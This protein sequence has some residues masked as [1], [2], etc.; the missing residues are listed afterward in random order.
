MRIR[1]NIYIILGI[2][3]IL[4]NLF[5]DFAEYIE[6]RSLKTDAA[7]SIGYFI[8]SHILLI[9][10]MLLL[11]IAYKIHQKMK[12]NEVQQMIEEIGKS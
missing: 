9:F 2:V 5:V 3:L 4:L 7:Y 8:G 12:R 10:G 6:R 11:R 1:K